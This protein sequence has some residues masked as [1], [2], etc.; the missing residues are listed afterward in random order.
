MK[1]KAA[2]TFPSSFTRRA[3][4]CLPLVAAFALGSLPGATLLTQAAPSGSGGVPIEILIVEGQGRVEVLRAGARSWDQA[5]PGQVLEVGDRL[6]A[7]PPG[8]AL[9][10]WSD[11]SKV[12]IDAR[13]ELEILPPPR[14]KA[15]AG[16]N[17]LS[18]ILYFFHRDKPAD[19]EFK[20]RTVTS[21]IRG[22]EFNVLLHAS[23]EELRRATTPKIAEGILRIRDGRVTIEPGYDG[24]YGKVRIFT[25]EEPATEPAEQQL[26]LF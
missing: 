10:R 22:T 7:R 26:T 23:E 21:A 20:S 16:F 18:G 17:L 1:T 25:G 2:Q 9:L 4:R 14:P 19:L 12:R 11:Q 3:Q 24:E 8:R 13:A 6:R 15:Q 5:Y